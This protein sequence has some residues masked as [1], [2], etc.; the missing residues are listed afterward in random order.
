MTFV[1][2]VLAVLRIALDR[3]VR[4][5]RGVRSLRAD[6]RTSPVRVCMFP[7]GVRWPPAANGRGAGCAVGV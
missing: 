2:I 7:P 1:A 5:R 6:T 4:H 3:P